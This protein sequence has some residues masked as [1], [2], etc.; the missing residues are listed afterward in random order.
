M[1]KFICMH[2]HFYQPPRENPW[3]GE[4]DPEPSAKPF[5][6]WNERIAKECYEA[7]IQAPILNSKGQVSLR[8][9]NF[10]K[11]SFDIGPTLL[12]WLRRKQPSTYKAI[13]QAD[14]ES[15]L[16]RQGHGNAIAQSYNHII[17]P[18]AKRRDK[19]TQI[20]WGIRDFKF[21]YKRK[22]EGMWLSESA[23]DRETMKIMADHGILFT[24]LA[25]HQAKRYRHVG[26]GSRWHTV[27]HEA[28]DIRHPYRVVLE[29]GKQFHVFF[30]DALISRAIAFQGLL[31]NGDQLVQ[32]LLG[33]FT[34]REREQLVSTA[35]DGESFG[36]HHKFGEMAIAY[37]LKK[38]EDQKLAQLTNYGEYLS[39]FGSYR[40][41]DIVENSSWSCSHGVERWRADCGCRLNHQEGWNQ[42]WR[43]VLREA[44]DALQ[45][46]VDSVFEAEGGVLLKNPWQARNDYIQVMLDDTVKERKKFLERNA[47]K[48][49]NEE[50]EKKVWD[51][52][53]AE[54][55][56]LFMYTSCGWFFDDISGLEPV[57]VMKFAAR[58]MELTQPYCKED[59]EKKLLKTLS[60]AKSNIPEHGTGENI[61]IKVVKSARNILSAPPLPHRPDSV[62]KGS[63]KEPVW[64][65]S[66]VLSVCP[67]SANPPSSTLS[68][69]ARL[70]PP[71]ILLRR[72]IRT[73]ESSP[74]RI[75]VC[76]S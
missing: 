50:E 76:R 23:V 67:T 22:P 24:V 9:N 72:L 21:H 41:A 56:S 75:N 68:R 13:I 54:K 26:F 2:G 27:H 43:T 36:H 63:K 65:L 16:K 4:V 37:G 19:V 73:S 51:L 62:Q 30:Y 34:L 46:S 3:T 64:V 11:L 58:A 39:R 35:T 49:L 53:E 32:R 38:I 60:A 44:F 12:S 57:Q 20:V 71:I 48:M 74:F 17:M 1:N 40:E 59:L 18:L 25:P 45:V 29:Q 7:N 70:W 10:S 69:A 47:K 15:V 52:L 61:F 66:A 42:K 28:I 5:H 6:D 31:I 14:Q 33:V 8:V 55:F